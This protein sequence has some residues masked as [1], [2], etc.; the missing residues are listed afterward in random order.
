M[1][2]LYPEEIISTRQKVGK[3]QE[4]T[5]EKEEGADQGDKIPS[6]SD[7]S[8]QTVGQKRDVQTR[9]DVDLKNEKETATP[10]KVTQKMTTQCRN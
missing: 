7:Q 9:D 5:V 8:L 2:I 6:K 1:D 3:E 4:P 10:E